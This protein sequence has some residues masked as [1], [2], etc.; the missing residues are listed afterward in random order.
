MCQVLHNRVKLNERVGDRCS[1]GECYAALSAQNPTHLDVE[2]KRFLGSNWVVHSNNPGC[3]CGV[4]KVLK[5]MGFVNSNIV[6]AHSFQVIPYV[7]SSACSK[8]SQLVLQ[9]L[10]L[11]FHILD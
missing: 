9:R 10:Q 1:C 2:V 7:V 6:Y 3:G 11:F 5:L 4:R 8:V